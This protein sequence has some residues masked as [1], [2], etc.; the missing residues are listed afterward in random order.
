M[1][2]LKREVP[3]VVLVSLM[4]TLNILDMLFWVFFADFELIHIG[5]NTLLP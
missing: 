2:R 5:W 4:L 1:P 3:E